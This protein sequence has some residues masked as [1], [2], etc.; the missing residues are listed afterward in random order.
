MVPRSAAWGRAAL[1]LLLIPAAPPEAADTRRECL[2]PGL[3][4]LAARGARS[5]PGAGLHPASGGGAEDRV[6]VF[7]VGRPDPDALRGL[8]VRMRTRGGEVWTADVPFAAVPR[9]AEVPGLERALL[10]RNARFLL[11][12]SLVSANGNGVRTRTGDAWTGLT[13]KDVV[14][15]IVDSGVDVTHEDFLHP[16]GTTRVRFYWD[17]NDSGGSPPRAAGGDTLYAFGSEWTAADIDGG[18]LPPGDPVGHG[19]HVAGIAA[20]S[21]R[22][23]RVDSLRYRYVGVAPEADLVVVAADLFL[24]T[25]VLDAVNYVFTRA[26]DLGKPAVVNLSLGSQFGPHD[27][28]TPLEAGINALCGPGRLAVAAAGNEG[29]DRIHAEIHVP[30]GGRDSAT[31]FVPAYTPGPVLNLFVVDAFYP[32]SD[33][34]AV[35]VVTPSG[36]RFG[37]YA[38]FET[39]EALTG[40]G[41]LFLA[42]VRWGTTDRQVQFDVSDFNPDTTSQAS[43]P[44]PASGV[45]TVV[46]ADRSGNGG[47]VD[48]WVPFATM[49]DV[50]GN[51]PFTLTGY[52]PAEEVSVP[53]TAERVLAVGSYNTK[54]CWPDSTG[55][56]QCT[57][58]PDSLAG[59]E[60][61]TFFSSR[62]PSRD[63]REKPEVVAPGFVIASARSHQM[64]AEQQ[65]AYRF[66][67]TLDPDREHFVFSGTSMA[68]PHVTG[69]VALLLQNRPLLTPEAARDRIRATVRHD[70]ATGTGWTPG[71]GHG[72]L[73]IVALV[74]TTVAVSGRQLVLSPTDAG[75][76]ELSWTAMETDPV[77][78]F[79]LLRRR[80]GEAAAVAGR[81]AGRGP[82]SWID[83][84]PRPGTAY[85]LWGWLR[86]GDRRLWAGAVW[87][88]RA[89][90]RLAVDRPRP[91]PFRSGT[92]LAFRAPA[93]EPAPAAVVLD[94]QGR[95]VRRLPVPRPGPGGEGSVAWDGRD[96][97]GRRVAAGSYWIYIRA[98]AEEAWTRVVRL[99]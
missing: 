22:G 32:R 29:E 16:D 44:A 13:G 74:D 36:A 52:D 12:R 59:L 96:D 25:G 85:E 35:T 70:T 9:L 81:F 64:D 7:L 98:G 79:D 23:S 61:L 41:T 1:L 99:P 67:R 40:E 2:D 30:P 28:T 92:A 82:H 42:H 90:L 57:S 39:A 94:A 54:R 68:A 86:T 33:S 87:T 46:F 37:P 17:Q 5:R 89:P 83:P 14:V 78:S 60:M 20:G 63:D 66:A 73:D 80:P 3:R 65:A 48:L 71:G 38:L 21:G 77:V 97:A 15:G 6:D 43:V 93:G 75:D 26:A 72:K 11:D 24:E 18:N 88:G 47:E 53:A 51:G 95:R 55:V 69:A 27:G 31:V 4:E 49:A 84:A 56:L 8:G 58:V 50:G 45:W 76:L 62:G 10:A 19:S 91:N 34:L